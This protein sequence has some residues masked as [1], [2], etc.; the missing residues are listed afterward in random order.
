MAEGSGERFIQQKYREL[1]KTAPV[2]HEQKRRKRAG[3][4]STEKPPEMIRDFMQVLER[5]HLTHRDDP[6]VMERIKKYYHKKHV[7][8]ASD[9]PQSYWNAQ[10]KMMIEEGRGGD[11]EMSGIKKKT[12]KDKS[13]NERTD[14]LFPDNL[15]KQNAEVVI[16]DQKST[17][18][19]WINYFTSPDA[20]VYP[21][22]AKYWAFNNMLKL[23]SFDKEKK[24]F[25]K[26]RKDTVAPFPDLNR[27]ALAYVVDVIIKKAKQEQIPAAE[28]NA[29]AKPH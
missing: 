11:L 22:W 5:T 27:E 18:D 21:M 2:K 15:K 26:R 10:A 28:N 25:G 19:N 9:I 3:E 20:D 12:L 7:I 23:S 24:Q 4:I 1:H 17:L 14:Y 16:S 6:R 8:E 13:G 29:D